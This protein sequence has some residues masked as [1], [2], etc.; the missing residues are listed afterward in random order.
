[1]LYKK[2]HRQYLRQFKVGGKFKYKYSRTVCEI[3]R[4]PHII[5]RAIWL[6]GYILIEFTGQYKGVLNIG[7]ISAI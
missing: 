1:M 2:I 6:E 4:E 7:R 3:T 5:H